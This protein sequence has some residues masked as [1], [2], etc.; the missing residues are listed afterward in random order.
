MPELLAAQAECGGI[1][2]AS[3]PDTLATAGGAPWAVA[4]EEETAVEP[5]CEV[6]GLA[7]DCGASAV[8]VMPWSEV[9]LSRATPSSTAPDSV[10]LVRPPLSR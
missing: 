5:W 6:A 4:V 10:P 3:D 1:V 7:L 8:P 9:Q 2:A